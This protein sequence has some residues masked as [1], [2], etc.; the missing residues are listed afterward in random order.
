MRSVCNP[1]FS[2]ICWKGRYDLLVHQRV[3]TA[4]WQSGGFDSLIAEWRYPVHL[5]D[6]YPIL[7]IVGVRS[8]RGGC[9]HWWWGWG[10]VWGVH[11]GGTDTDQSH[12]HVTGRVHRWAET[13][14]CKHPRWLCDMSA[15]TRHSA[16]AGSIL[17]HR[18]RRWTLLNQPWL[19]VSC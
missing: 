9:G 11:V 17:A 10:G 3:S 16:N 15:D 12:H 14:T 19:N 18:L 8:R 5:S 13:S 6:L 1:I 2:I 7:W 4:T